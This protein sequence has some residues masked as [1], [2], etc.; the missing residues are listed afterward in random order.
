MQTKK[1]KM[2]TKSTQ[3][4]YADIIEF[5]IDQVQ[6]ST[7]DS[8]SETASSQD[9]QKITP[10]LAEAHRKLESEDTKIK[11]LLRCLADKKE[12]LE[13]KKKSN[14]EKD[15]VISAKEE[16]LAT[17]GEEKSKLFDFIGSLQRENEELRKTMR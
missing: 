17:V 5:E 7:D 6:G 3:T 8:N 10:Q 14:A 13:L 4:D 12:Q 16:L 11:L 15:R 2:E 9:T 1:T